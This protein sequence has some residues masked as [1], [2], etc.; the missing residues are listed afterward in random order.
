MVRK[1]LLVFTAASALM[2]VG[3]FAGA[4]DSPA[5][6]QTAPPQQDGGRHHPGMDPERR[7][8]ELT[9]KLNLT[10]DQQTKVKSTLESAKS[11]MESLRGSST[12]QQD[13]H[14]KMMD[15]RSTAN[16]QI[17]SILDAGQQKKFDQIQEKQEERMESRHG[18]PPPDAN[19][20]SAPQQQ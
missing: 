14:A 5:D 13:R 15:I 3:P 8:A 12:S 18:G 16:S 7:T 6:N 2:V 20:G 17:R 1:Y 11:Q 19:Q 9:K 4:Q 10:P